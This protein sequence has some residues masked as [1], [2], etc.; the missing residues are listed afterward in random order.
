MR[1]QIWLLTAMG[2]RALGLR[3]REY[4]IPQQLRMKKRSRG[5]TED[6]FRKPCIAFSVLDVIGDVDG[7]L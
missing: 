5:I 7:F 4:S 1:I 3:R 2:A 6:E